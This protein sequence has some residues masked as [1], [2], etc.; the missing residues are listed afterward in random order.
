MSAGQ[1][2]N[3]DDGVLPGTAMHVFAVATG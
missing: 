1:L 2:P 3:V